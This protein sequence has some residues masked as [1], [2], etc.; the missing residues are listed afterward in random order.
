ARLLFQKA[1]EAGVGRFAN[2]DQIEEY[3]ARVEFARRHTDL[4]SPD[5][6]RALESLCCGL[7]SFAELAE[8]GLLRAL[9]GQLSASEARALDELAPATLTLPSGRRIRIR[10]QR[11]RPPWAASRLQDF[12]G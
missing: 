9:S 7:R 6:P 4:P 8:A 11:D 10:Y 12:F 2:P 1:M 3:I 5:V